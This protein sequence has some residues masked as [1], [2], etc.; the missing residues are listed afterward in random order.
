MASQIRVSVSFHQSLDC[1]DSLFCLT[2]VL[3]MI[4]ATCDTLEIKLLSKHTKFLGRVLWSTVRDYDI[5]YALSSKDWH[6]S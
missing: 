1:Y 3:G 6:H 5:W 4:Q 2:T